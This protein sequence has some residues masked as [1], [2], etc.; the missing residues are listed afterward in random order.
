[1]ANAPNPK[2]RWARSYSIGL[3]VVAL[4]A[5][6]IPAFADD[7][8][9]LARFV[10][11]WTGRGTYRAGASSDPEQIYCKI[12]NRLADN[13]AVLEQKGRC[14]IPSE[15]GLVKGRIS[16]E[17]AGRYD[18]SLQSISTKGPATLAG[19]GSNGT[20]TFT[21]DFIDR[22]TNRPGKS[23]LRFVA[24]TDNY[25]LTSSEVGAKNAPYLSTD[26]VF[27]HN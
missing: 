4:M 14:A 23:T 17:G 26:I 20:L 6:L 3:A 16:A 5:G 7:D 8:P 22:L 18:G 24:G 15:S 12:T 9:L 1:M 2:Q 13:G 11:D 25:R 27:T 10:G 19:V 21:A